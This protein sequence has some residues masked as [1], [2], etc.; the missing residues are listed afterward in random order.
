LE[1]ENTWKEDIEKWFGEPLDLKRGHEYAA[2]IFNAAFGDGE[3]FKFNGNV[4]NFGLIDNLPAGCCV[5]V[6]VL[7][8]RNGLE[9]LRVGKLPDHLAILVGASAG[10]EELVVDAYLTGD[11][12]KVFQAVCM[13]P[14]SSAVLS[15]AE[16]KE[17]VDEMLDANRA[18][19]P[20][21]GKK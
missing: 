1:R 16:I 3:M 5:E 10:I 7:A 20:V 19:L 14:L 4:R 2:S 11:S 17:M 15:L 12:R 18:Y 8:S 9:P 13:D 21:F 6:P